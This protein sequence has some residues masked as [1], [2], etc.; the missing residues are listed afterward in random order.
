[1][2]IERASFSGGALHLTC[3][4][5]DALKFVY[6]FAAGDYDILPHKDKK[7]RSKDANAYAWVLIHKISEKLGVPPIN[8]YRDAVRDIGGVYL[9]PEEVQVEEVYNYSSEWVGEHLGR[10]V[11]IFPSSKYGFVNVMRVYG[12]SDYDTKQM[13]RFIDGLIQDARALDIETRDQAWIQSLLDS[14]E[15]KR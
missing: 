1:M 3:S 5:S 12:S 13:S 2:K 6:S 7:K 9:N 11:Q 10:Q 4:P 15:A 8:I 14:W